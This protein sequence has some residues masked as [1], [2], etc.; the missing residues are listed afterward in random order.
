MK[1]MV[2]ALVLQVIIL[3]LTTIDYVASRKRK[4]NR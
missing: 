3:T 1:L 2:A 4:G